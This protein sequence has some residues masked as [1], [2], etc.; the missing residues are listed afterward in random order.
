MS[1]P[2]SGILDTVQSLDDVFPR[3]HGPSVE[4]EALPS[5]DELIRA[6]QHEIEDI[7]DGAVERVVDDHRHVVTRAR[8]IRYSWI[9]RI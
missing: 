6:P 2:S 4:T 7:A 3:D 1:I 9:S 8:W 5:G